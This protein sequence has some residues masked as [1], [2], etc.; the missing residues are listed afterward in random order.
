M[1][2]RQPLFEIVKGADPIIACALHDGHEVRN[3]VAK[4]FHIS[5][6]DRRREEDP[7]TG[8]WTRI[9]STRLIARRSRFEVDLNRPRQKSVY[10]KSEDS[11]D[12]RVWEKDLPQA[13]IDK[14]LAIYDEFYARCRKIFSELINRYGTIIVLDLHSYN[15][16]RDG[17]DNPP[18]DSMDNPEVNIGTGSLDRA[19]FSPLVDRFMVELAQ[20][21]F[22]GRTLDVRENIRFFGGHFSQWVH[23]AFP[24]QACVLAVEFKKFFM[25]EWSG[26]FIGDVYSEIPKALRATLPGLYEELE[27]IQHSTLRKDTD[28]TGFSSA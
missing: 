5:D 20:Y 19:Y 4:L 13:L 18:A 2:G 12:I 1:I 26:E 9:A 16:R 11:W 21:D 3:E 8:N 27:G 6:A 22:L 25:D 7:G 10:I 14:S 15:H 28:E 17:P 24:H 23:A